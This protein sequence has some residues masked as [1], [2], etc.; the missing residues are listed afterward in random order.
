MSLPGRWCRCKWACSDNH[1]L[2][3]RRPSVY[4]AAVFF[5]DSSIDRVVAPWKPDQ[6]VSNWNP[7]SCPLNRVNKHARRRSGHT[8]PPN[9]NT[10]IQHMVRVSVTHPVRLCQQMDK[11]KQDDGPTHN[12]HTSIYSKSGKQP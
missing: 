8:R 7:W 6:R 4:P 5:F 12:L 11:T 1:F 2:R 9:T 3:Q 10:N